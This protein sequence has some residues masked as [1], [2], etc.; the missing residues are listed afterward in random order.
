MDLSWGLTKFSPV[1]PTGWDSALFFTFD[2][3][4]GALKREYCCPFNGSSIRAGCIWGFGPAGGGGGGRELTFVA[5]TTAC[6]TQPAPHTVNSFLNS[7]K[8]T[9]RKT[10]SLS[11]PLWA[12]CPTSNWSVPRFGNPG[13]VLGSLSQD[14]TT[15][16]DQPRQARIRCERSCATGGIP[17]LRG[18]VSRPPKEVHKKVVGDLNMAWF[19]MSLFLGMFFLKRRHQRG[20]HCRL[21]QVSRPGARLF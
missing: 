8:K 11:L 1:L 10:V 16:P 19:C 18:K 13:T 12:P 21:R 7:L 4:G 17:C 2:K 20:G 5:P 15:L 9:P 3:N 6:F 14:R